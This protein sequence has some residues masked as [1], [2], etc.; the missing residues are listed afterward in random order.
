[1]SLKLNAMFPLDELDIEEN[2]SSHESIKKT[3]QY[4]TLGK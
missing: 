1:M 3:V 2:C 4:D